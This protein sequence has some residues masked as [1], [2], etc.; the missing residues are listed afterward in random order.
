M[1][2]SGNVHAVCMCSGQVTG[3][4]NPATTMKGPHCRHVQQWARA[5]VKHPNGVGAR[6]GVRWGT[7][8]KETHSTTR[9][10]N[11]KCIE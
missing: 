5:A 10:I 2:G 3:G 8:V 1:N 11:C 6:A 4:K 7:G 9:T